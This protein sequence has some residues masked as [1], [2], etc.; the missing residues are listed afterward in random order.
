MRSNVAALLFACIFS[1]KQLTKRFQH[2]LGKRFTR[3]KCTETALN[4]LFLRSKPLSC[5]IFKP[6]GLR[7]EKFDMSVL[8]IN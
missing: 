1:V 4:G 5:Q 2:G 8:K 7:V 3:V 6:M